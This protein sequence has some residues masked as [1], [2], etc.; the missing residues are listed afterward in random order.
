MIINI[1][2]TIG[3]ASAFIATFICYGLWAKWCAKS[4]ED[5]ALSAFFGVVVP[6][7]ILVSALIAKGI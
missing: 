6:L 7:I 1:I 2:Q 4:I 3:I 5:P